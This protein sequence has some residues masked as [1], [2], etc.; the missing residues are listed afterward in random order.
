[1]VIGVPAAV[2]AADAGAVLA[3]AKPMTAG[4]TTATHVRSS[5]ASENVRIT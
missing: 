3:T 1:L 2:C 4:A 5:E